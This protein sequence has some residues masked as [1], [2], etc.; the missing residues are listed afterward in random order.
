MGAFGLVTGALV[1]EADQYSRSSAVD[2]GP[3]AMGLEDCTTLAAVTAVS[4]WSYE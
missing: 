1:A 3:D 2:V 4:S